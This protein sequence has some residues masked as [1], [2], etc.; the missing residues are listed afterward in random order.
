MAA[1]VNPLQQHIL[2]AAER[3]Q[4]RI[5]QELHD[6]LGQHLT[7][8]AFLAKALARKLADKGA[9]EATDAEKLTQLINRSVSIT[10]GLAH[11]LRPVGDEDNAL[12]VALRQLAMD[13]TDLYE[14]DGQFINDEPVLIG[15]PYV[16]HHLFRIAQ[17]AVN[18]AMRHGHPKRI[19]IELDRHVSGRNHSIVMS[20]NN[21]GAPFRDG[22][23][24]SGGMGLAGM[25]YRAKLIGGRID[26][27]RDARP[28]VRV[29]VSVPEH[30]ADTLG[31][32]PATEPDLEGDH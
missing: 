12:M 32:P 11:G 25:R 19:V 17:E 6:G 9:P 23:E 30:L 14:I 16:A 18:N 29:R 27:R 24:S 7:G 8:L 20:I 13:I 4:E 21:D 31:E 26:L 2:K 3:E 1:I 22:T 10:R 15:S 5:G 28:M